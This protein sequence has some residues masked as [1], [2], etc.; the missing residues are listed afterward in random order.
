MTDV[1][2]KNQEDVSMQNDLQVKENEVIVEDSQKNFLKPENKQF[3]NLDKTA[4]I[5]GQSEEDLSKEF[6]E[7]KALKLFK[8]VDVDLTFVRD[9]LLL[10]KKIDEC[11]KF[12]FGN[13]VV[14]SK[15]IKEAKRFLKGKKLGVFAAVCYPYGEE[16]YEVKKYA[17]KK[18]FSE[19]ADGVYLPLSIIDLKNGKFEQ[20]R[21]ELVKMIKRY[22]HKKI[23]I[24]LEIGE[25]NF[26]NVEKIVKMLLKTRIVGIVSGTGYSLCSKP[27]SGATDLHSLSSGKRTVIAYSNT[28]KSREVVSLFSVADRVFLKNA[29][30]IALD[31]KTNL[32]Y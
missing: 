14:N 29:P 4:V 9:S 27:F 10:K 23:F 16:I 30:K 25:L 24:V 13:V 2:V 17:V 11:V 3:F 26:S 20:V 22:K 15:Q 19:G 32:E 21:R 31:L 5:F 6:K 28:E 1:L 12:G 8:R 18:A 7:Y